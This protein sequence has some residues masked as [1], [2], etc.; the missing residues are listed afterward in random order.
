MPY[1]TK[2][3]EIISNQ[4]VYCPKC[5][6]QIP[7][8]SYSVGKTRKPNVAGVLNIVSGVIMI[9]VSFGGC[10]QVINLGR[11]QDAWM[12][13]LI[14]PGVVALVG[15][16]NAISRKKWALALAGSIC[17]IPALLGIVSTICVMDSKQEFR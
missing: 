16:I 15:G 4:M 11:L 5:R 13:F 9:L 3:G 14:I 8:V 1:C 2:C 17:A 7:S 6:A 10:M 12:F